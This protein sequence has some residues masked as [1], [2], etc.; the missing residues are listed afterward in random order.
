[1]ASQPPEL[2]E[3]VQQYRQ[4][5]T[6]SVTEKQEKLDELGYEDYLKQM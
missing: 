2:L 5:L 6:S 3:K 1:L 4:N